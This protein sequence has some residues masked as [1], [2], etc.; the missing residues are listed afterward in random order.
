M[1]LM[2]SFSDD[3]LILKHTVLSLDEM[4]DMFKEIMNAWKS[5][6]N[7]KI[8]AVMLSDQLKEHPEFQAL[9]ERLFDERN[10]TMTRK[11]LE[12]IRLRQ[13]T[14]MIPF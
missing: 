5:G 8:E 2:L 4:D 6:D 13:K 10:E 7:K 1:E 3:D 14:I 11:I 12:T 9:F